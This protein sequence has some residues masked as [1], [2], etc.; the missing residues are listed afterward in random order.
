MIVLTIVKINVSLLNMDKDV[1]L[2]ELSS[3]EQIPIAGRLF[4]DCNCKEIKLSNIILSREAVRSI[5]DHTE[6]LTINCNQPYLS[7][8][9][10]KKLAISFDADYFNVP[11]KVSELTVFSRISTI[12]CSDNLEKFTLHSDSTVNLMSCNNLNELVLTDTK[13]RVYGDFMEYLG[14]LSLKYNIYEILYNYNIIEGIHKYVS[15]FKNIYEYNGFLNRDILRNLPNVRKIKSRD[16]IGG[17]T[18][19]DIPDS[20]EDMNFYIVYTNSSDIL[21]RKPNIKRIYHYEETIK[22]DDLVKRYPDVYFYLVYRC[23][24]IRRHNSKLITL[25]QLS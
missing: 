6:S 15:L 23:D 16:T 19:D 17:I 22:P 25:R 21:D 2:L 20:L 1:D 12:Y 9:S 24:I 14:C 3:S 10:T 8:L 5:P 13:G 18:I 7:E 11:T 4:D